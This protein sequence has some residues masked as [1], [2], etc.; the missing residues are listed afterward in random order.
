[1]RVLRSISPLS[2]CTGLPWVRACRSG[3]H[4]KKLRLFHQSTENCSLDTLISD[5]PCSFESQRLRDRLATTGVLLNALFRKH[6]IVMNP[7]DR[8]SSGCMVF[9]LYLQYPNKESYPCKSGD[10][11]HRNPFTGIIWTRLSN[12]KCSCMFF[13]ILPHI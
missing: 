10:D 3:A 4:S 7:I 13:S 12:M 5:W 1:M 8:L 6:Y 2:K 11:G 9:E